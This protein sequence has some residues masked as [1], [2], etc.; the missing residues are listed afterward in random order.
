MFRPKLFSTLKKYTLALFWGDLSAGL[1]VGIV[2]LPLAIAFAIA[3]GVTP[4]R[5]LTTAIL[6]GFIISALGGSRV[7]IGGPTG[8]FVVIVYGIVE[9]YGIDGLI[10]C[11][12]MAGVM[13]ILMGLLQLGSI[14]KFIP[15]PLTVGFTSGIAI[16]IFSSQIKDFFGLKT[17]ALPGDFIE[18]WEIYFHAFRTL[19]HT[20]TLLSLASLAIL[21]LWPRINRKIPASAIA[22]LFMT[23]IVHFFHLP[24]ETIGSRF[25]KLSA[26]LPSFNFPYFTLAQARGL[27]SP[28]F[29]VALL[30]AIESLLS[31]TVADGMIGGRHRSNTELIAQGIANLVAPLFGGIPATGAIARTATNIKNGAQTPVA[32]IIH[33]LTLLFIVLLFGSWASQ[34]PLC[35]LSAIL[36]VVAYHMSEWHAF[37]SLLKAPRMD[38]AVLIVTFLLTVF[39]DLTVAVEVGL[40]L[41]LVLFMKRMT[42]VTSIREITSEISYSEPSY[43]EKDELGKPRQKD[44]VVYEAEGAFFFGI[45]ELLRNTL[46]IG[47]EPPKIFILRMRHVLA[48][49]ATGLQ[50]L[51]DL[52]RQC[53]H[54]KTQ[55]MISGIGAQPFLAM[56]RSGFLQEIGRDN[57]LATLDEAM[58]RVQALKAA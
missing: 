40:L 1:I 35:V 53:Q 15:Y 7:Q 36:V 2:A 44:V 38:I 26:G 5:G 10:L 12:L 33:A 6:A 9:K 43:S 47:S 27:I 58:R 56:Q 37:K 14:I 41:S 19:D 3:S 11:S 42:D 55:L 22:L 24:V 20:T 28:A 16:I 18:K 45:A 32:G 49:D 8:A 29:T 4:E 39:F 57:V 30:G 54:H 48:L 13:L 46:D 52:H 31:A 34:I 50:A 21:A 17:P 25:G 51:R 23:L